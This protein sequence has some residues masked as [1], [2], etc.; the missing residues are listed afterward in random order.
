MQILQKTFNVYL[1]NKV[2]LNNNILA[3]LYIPIT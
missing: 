1:Q 3:D 2:Y